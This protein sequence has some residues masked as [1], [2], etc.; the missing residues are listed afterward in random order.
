M[1]LWGSATMVAGFS[2][3]SLNGFPLDAVRDYLVKTAPF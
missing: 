1:G 2:Y 3:F